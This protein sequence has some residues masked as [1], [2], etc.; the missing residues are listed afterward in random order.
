MRIIRLPRRSRA[1]Q[2]PTIQLPVALRPP[3]QRRG[4]PTDTHRLGRIAESYAAVRYTALAKRPP[5]LCEV[6]PI[7]SGP[8]CAPANESRTRPESPPCGPR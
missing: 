6:R 5:P 3:T 8:G 7:A 4:D 2:R 1:D